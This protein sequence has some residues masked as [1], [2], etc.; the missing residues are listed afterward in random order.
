MDGV[1]KDNYSMVSVISKHHIS[2]YRCYV[3]NLNDKLLIR[4]LM[5]L[6][7]QKWKYPDV[8]HETKFRD[9]KINYWSRKQ[10]IIG[11]TQDD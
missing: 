9:Y 5:G 1:N 11:S 10:N 4:K 7:T 2:D 6:C 8:E 3:L